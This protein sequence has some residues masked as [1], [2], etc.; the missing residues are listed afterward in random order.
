LPLTFLDLKE[1]LPIEI[2]E[3]VTQGED[4]LGDRFLNRARIWLSA[5]L[6]PCGITQFDENDT[7]IRQILLYRALYELYAYV[8]KEE[9]AFD[10]REAAEEMLRGYFGPCVDASAEKEKSNP[11]PV[12]AVKEG[13]TTWNGF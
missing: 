3:A 9:L 4:T 8:E 2:W 5:R 10:K 6:K 12:G 1:E 7:I 11:L 13:R